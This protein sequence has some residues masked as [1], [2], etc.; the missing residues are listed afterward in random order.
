[1]AKS[2]AKAPV[3]KEKSYEELVDP[4]ITG[5]PADRGQQPNLGEFGPDTLDPV[6]INKVNPEK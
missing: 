5:E 4:D 3:E 2:K 6:N 1:M